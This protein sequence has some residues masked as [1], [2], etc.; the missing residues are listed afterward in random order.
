MPATPE[1]SDPHDADDP[2]NEEIRAR[3]DA[4]RIEGIRKLANEGDNPW[5]VVATRFALQVLLG[6][7]DTLTTALAAA[8]APGSVYILVDADYVTGTGENVS[9]HRTLESASAKLVRLANKEGMEIHPADTTRDR[10]Y[11][12]G[13]RHRTHSQGLCIEDVELES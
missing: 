11:A 4:R 7:I 1:T 2:T 3:G 12:T 9:A 5:E 10:P 13:G 8:T 6:E